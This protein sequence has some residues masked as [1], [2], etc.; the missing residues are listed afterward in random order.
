MNIFMAYLVGFVG[1]NAA[2]GATVLLCRHLSW[3][4][5]IAAGVLLGLVIAVL[6]FKYRRV[7]LFFCAV[8][9]MAGAVLVSMDVRNYLTARAGGV[10]E[11][12]SVRQ[13]AEYRQAGGFRFRDAVLRKD[14][15]GQVLVGHADVQ[16]YRKSNWYHVAAVVP[17]DWKPEEPVTVWA[18]CGELASCLQDWDKP[19]GAGVRL[20]AETESIPDYLKAVEQAVSVNSV[21]TAPNPVFITWVADPAAKIAGFKAAA[22][23]TAKIWNV[24]WFLTAVTGGLITYIRKRKAAG[25]P[26]EGEPP[27]A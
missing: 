4:F 26:S 9:A 20:N 15:R 14:V 18:A 27:A 5:G 17:A 6:S 10:V 8:Y 25:R 2:I 22:W 7:V 1:L 24:V 12:L 16:G 21:T 19:F 23:E 13:I 11:D 3:G